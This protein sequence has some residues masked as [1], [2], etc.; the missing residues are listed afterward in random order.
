[1]TFA[2]R[3]EATA[4]QDLRVRFGFDR[5]DVLKSVDGL[6][7]QME[8]V[9]GKTREQLGCQRPDKQQQLVSRGRGI[10]CDAESR[11]PRM[12]GQRG[13]HKVDRRFARL[14]CCARTR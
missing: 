3:L 4:L 13:R 14:E 2:N 6:I 12:L 8:A 10:L 5:Y 11:D 1:M 7:R 9:S